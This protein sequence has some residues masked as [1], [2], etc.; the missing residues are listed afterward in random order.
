M[1]LDIL[2]PHYTESWSLVEPFFDSIKA[3]RAVDFD[4]IRVVMVN[5]GDEVVF[6]E[7]LFKKYPF[8][9]DYHVIQHCGVSA[10]RNYAFDHG[11][12]N[13][14][15]FCDCDDAFANMY[16]LHFVFNNLGKGL[17]VITSTFLVE[18]IDDDGAMDVMVKENDV[19]FVHG[20]VYR[21][22]Y[23]A[24]KDIRWKPEL[25]IHEDGF[26]N[27]L[28][29]MLADKKGKIETPYY[30]WKYRPDSVA[31]KTDETFV[32]RTYKNLIDTRL[33]LTKEA[34]KRGRIA[35]ARGF[36]VKTVLDS[37]YDFNKTVALKPENK[38]LV[39]EAEKA[40]KRFYIKYRKD[41]NAC[42]ID[43]ISQVANISRLNAYAEGLRI[44]QRTLS[45]WLTHIMKEVD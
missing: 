37:Y 12:A 26:F 36:I 20:K 19:T 14:V 10:T 22:E 32:L 44:E 38:K 5:D 31:S 4:N 35:D 8:R 3:Q 45:Q 17:D 33:A 34:K 29:L 43:E 25:T 2:V 6:D 13:Y 1:K 7:E 41:Y 11:E 39:E 28:A 18:Y 16:G 27:C 24:E 9:I 21:R 42:T 30:V 23:L 40:F 15:M